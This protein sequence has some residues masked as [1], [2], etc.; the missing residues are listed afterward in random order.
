M[1][2]WKPFEVGGYQLK[3]RRGSSAL[4]FSICFDPKPDVGRA[5]CHAMASWTACCAKAMSLPVSVV[6]RMPPF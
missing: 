3:L 6:I 4:R 5:V 2:R 1:E